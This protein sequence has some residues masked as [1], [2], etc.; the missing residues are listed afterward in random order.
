[1]LGC[2]AE[3]LRFTGM[4][5]RL[6]HPD[7]LEQDRNSFKKLV[8]GEI[9]HLHIDKRYL[10]RDGR[11][12]WASVELSLLRDAAGKPQYILG[13]AAEITQP[14]RRE[15]K[16]RAS[17]RPHPPLIQESPLALALYHPQ[18]RSP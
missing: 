11:L 3:E 2:T 7:D 16:L 8:A 9:D 5:D 4:F 1:M 6:T 18:I 13:L 15:E 17:E 12:V 14:K 10:L